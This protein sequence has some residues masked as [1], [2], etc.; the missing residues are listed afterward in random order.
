MPRTGQTTAGAGLKA[1]YKFTRSF[2]M[3]ASLAGQN[4]VDPS[5]EASQSSTVALGAGYRF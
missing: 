4:D 3:W 5:G 1:Q 2:R